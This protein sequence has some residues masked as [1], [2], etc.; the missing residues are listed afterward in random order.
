M[1]LPT[2]PDSLVVGQNDSR[3]LDFT[4]VFSRLH[5]ATGLGRLGESSVQC[6]DANARFGKMSAVSI[7]VTIPKSLDG[8]LDVQTELPIS[9]ESRCLIVY[10][11]LEETCTEAIR[12]FSHQFSEN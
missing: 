1:R 4:K 10:N 9:V 7:V 2:E 5:C 12:K 6:M 3:S 8:Q 11:D